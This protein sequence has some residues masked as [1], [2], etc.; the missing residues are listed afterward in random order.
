MKVISVIIL[1]IFN[2]CLRF[3]DIYC[4]I[5]NYILNANVLY[6]VLV[7]SFISGFLRHNNYLC[8]KQP[9]AS[10]S[11]FWTLSWVMIVL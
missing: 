3:M 4:K 11:V 6:I 10:E 7:S 9:D 8:A 2:R 5:P 1:L